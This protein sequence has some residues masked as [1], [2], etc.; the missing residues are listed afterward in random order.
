MNSS[1]QITTPAT[2]KENIDFLN[3]KGTLEPTSHYALKSG[4]NSFHEQDICMFSKMVENS[5]SMVRN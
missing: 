4:I 5:K 3:T 2:Q 1:D